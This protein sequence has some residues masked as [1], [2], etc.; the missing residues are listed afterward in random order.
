MYV[1]QVELVKV[2]EDHSYCIQGIITIGSVLIVGIP[3]KANLADGRLQ[4]KVRMT[5]VDCAN[6]RHK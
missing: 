5:A 4:L 6:P 1:S 3:G 2:S